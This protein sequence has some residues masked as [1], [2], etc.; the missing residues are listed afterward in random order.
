MNMVWFGL[1]CFDLAAAARHGSVNTAC[2]CVYVC[3]GAQFS[4]S[5]TQLMFVFQVSYT[6]LLI[7]QILVGLGSKVQDAQ[8]VYVLSAFVFGLIIATG[9][10]LSMWHL[11]SDT[12][13]HA[14]V[15]G[16]MW[17]SQ[18]VCVCGGGGG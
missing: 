3:V 16:V 17:G 2:V 1:I 6:L 10:C 13:V 11:A 5:G 7:V 8:A 14:P 12:C 15:W 9:F 4:S 18:F